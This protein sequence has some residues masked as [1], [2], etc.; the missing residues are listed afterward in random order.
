MEWNAKDNNILIQR[1]LRIW[2]VTDKYQNETT[3]Q[4]QKNEKVADVINKIYILKKKKKK[5]STPRKRGKKPQ[6]QQ[7]QNNQQQAKNKQ[8]NKQMN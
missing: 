5:K 7:Q 3:K 8:Q 1:W 2:Q 6:Q 4:L